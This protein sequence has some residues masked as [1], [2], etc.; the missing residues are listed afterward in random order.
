[1]FFFG[2]SP[3]VSFM[4]AEQLHFINQNSF[5]DGYP[6]G[7]FWQLHYRLQPPC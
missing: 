5:L 3:V 4:N 2:I 7:V 1:L 6:A